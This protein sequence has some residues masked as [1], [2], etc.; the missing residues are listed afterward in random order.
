MPELCRWQSSYVSTCFT[1][2]SLEQEVFD[3]GGGEEQLPPQKK[4]LFQC[5]LARPTMCG[6]RLHGVT[7][8]EHML[9]ASAPDAAHWVVL[10]MAGRHEVPS[11]S[12]EKLVQS[13]SQC[14]YKS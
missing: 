13:Q 6:G 14:G 2:E 4:A 5:Q 11:T 3:P 10:G 9:E 1:V 8:K 12:S 7:I